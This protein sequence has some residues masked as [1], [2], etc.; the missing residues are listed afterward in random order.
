MDAGKRARLYAEYVAMT[1]KVTS[2][3]YCHRGDRESLLVE[4]DY[5]KARLAW[6]EE[7]KMPLETTTG[8]MDAEFIDHTRSAIDEVM[9][10]IE[11]TADDR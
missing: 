10:M 4:L 11:A 6:Y 1:D 2:E 8:A 5:L 7:T 9:A 3:R